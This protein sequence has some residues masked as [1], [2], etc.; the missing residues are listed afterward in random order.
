MYLYAWDLEERHISTDFLL[1]LNNCWKHWGS[2]FALPPAWAM[3]VLPLEPTIH[4]HFS[5]NSCCPAKFL[6]YIRNN[7]P[8]GCHHLLLIFTMFFPSEC[9]I[10]SRLSKTAVYMETANINKI[11]NK[12][13]FTRQLAPTLNIPLWWQHVNNE[14]FHFEWRLKTSSMGVLE[15]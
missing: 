9:S 10:K 2:H 14:T 3:A 12:L 6:K 8:G 15:S 1:N 4:H 5:C 13:T 7:P 11:D